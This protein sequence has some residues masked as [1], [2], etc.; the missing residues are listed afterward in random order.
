MLNHQEFPITVFIALGSNLKNPIAQ[1]NQALIA[2]NEIADTQLV[3]RSPWYQSRAV[4]PGQQEDYINGVAQL[5]TLLTP[6][7]LLEELQKIE[8]QQGRERVVHWGARTLDLDILLYGDLT[9]DHPRLQIPHPC[10]DQRN[11]VVKP[12]LDIAPHLQLP[13]GQYLEN[14]NLALGMEG[15]HQLP[16]Q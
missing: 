2:L 6:L 14:I 5:S 3:N 7:A 1:V 10:M 16:N 15:L 13:N 9:M 11:F 8:I 4:G 12:L